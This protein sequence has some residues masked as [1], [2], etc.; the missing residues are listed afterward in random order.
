MHGGSMI[1]A[2]PALSLKNTVNRIALLLSE[3]ETSRIRR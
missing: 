3:I 1:L 2:T